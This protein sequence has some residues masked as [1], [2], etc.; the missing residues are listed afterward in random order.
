MVGDQ[1]C[2]AQTLVDQLEYAPVGE[3]RHGGPCE[4]GQD[5]RVVERSPEQ[6]PDIHKEIAASL[7]GFGLLLGRSLS[8]VQ[9]RPLQS[10]RG[11]PRKDL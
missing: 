5:V 6:R 4:V 3:P 11:I 9:Q 2:P 8:A 1:R 7:V 10:L